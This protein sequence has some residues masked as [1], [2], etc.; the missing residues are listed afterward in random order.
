MIKTTVALASAVIVWHRSNV[1]VTLVRSIIVRRCVLPAMEV[2]LRY[3]PAPVATP[4]RT[5]DVASTHLIWQQ[6][7]KDQLL[8]TLHKHSSI[9]TP[10]QCYFPY[11]VSSG[12]GSCW[13]VSPVTAPQKLVLGCIREFYSES[14][15]I[16]ILSIAKDQP[17]VFVTSRTTVRL[18]LHC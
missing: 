7:V 5:V 13:E 6:D 1:L 12:G 11:L 4:G 8:V 14:S 3:N 17:Q 16:F 18:N 9:W 2:Y 10:I 15:C